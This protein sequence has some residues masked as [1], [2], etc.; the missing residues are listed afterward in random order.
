MYYNFT[1]YYTI[2]CSDRTKTYKNTRR[3]PLPNGETPKPE[4]QRGLPED[5]RL[6]DLPHVRTKR[7]VLQ[8]FLFQSETNGPG[9]VPLRSWP[10]QPPCKTVTT[11]TAGVPPKL[12]LKIRFQNGLKILAACNAAFL[13]CLGTLKTGLRAATVVF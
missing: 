9:T 7:M 1:I 4:K 3:L 6:P 2:N 12:R 11:F 8:I 5:F 10:S 13:R